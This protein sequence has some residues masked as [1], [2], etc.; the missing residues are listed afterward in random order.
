MQSPAKNNEEYETH[1]EYMYQDHIEPSKFQQD[2]KMQFPKKQNKVRCSFSCWNLTL[3]SE[4]AIQ[5]KPKV[6][7]QINSYPDCDNHAE[8]FKSTNKKINVPVLSL[9]GCYTM[10]K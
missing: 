2:N 10:K 5:N 9:A 6:E 3:S 4:E 8:T 7:I 1:H